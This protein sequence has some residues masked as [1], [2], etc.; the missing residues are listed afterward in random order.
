MLND[1]T[2]AEVLGIFFILLI[3]FFILLNRYL[4]SDSVEETQ[5]L[6]AIAEDHKE[7]SETTSLTIE[8]GF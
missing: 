5:Q 2:I 3:V 7:Q 1:L 6:E 8:S 4:N